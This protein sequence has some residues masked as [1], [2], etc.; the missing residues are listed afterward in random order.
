[1][2]SNPT[3]AIMPFRSSVEIQAHAPAIT[4]MTIKAKAIDPRSS[5]TLFLPRHGLYLCCNA[6]ISA[7]VLAFPASKISQPTLK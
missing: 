1:M 5:P 7:L 3:S 4:A 6:A 2:R